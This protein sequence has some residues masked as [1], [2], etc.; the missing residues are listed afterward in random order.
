MNDNSKS[1]KHGSCNHDHEHEEN[2][3]P[4]DVAHDIPFFGAKVESHDL[5]QQGR[6]S[7]PLPLILPQVVG[8]RGAASYAPENTLE[9]L[10]SAAGMGI[11]WVEFD[12]KLTKDGVPILFHDD[13]AERTTSG[14]GKIAEMSLADIQELDAGDWFG[15][16][17]TGVKVPTLEEAL[18]VIIDLG[19]AIN[20]EIKPCAGREVETAEVALDTL[21]RIW[22]EDQRVIISSFS[23]VSLEVARDMC[24]IWARGYLID[25]IPENWKEMAAHLKATTVNINGNNPAIN[26]DFVEQIIDAGYGVLA[27]TINDPMRAQQLIAWGVDGVFSDVPD[28]IAET[29]LTRH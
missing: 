7:K 21:S 23:D 1:I 6:D 10:H 26:R 28:V 11:E 22:D 16:S 17:Y 12:V 14:S 25:E 29:V 4:E 18:D 19:L 5:V 9:G 13:K 3:K 20:M 8:H 27:Y 2:K 24:P 15:E